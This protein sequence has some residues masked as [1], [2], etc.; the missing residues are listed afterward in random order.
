MSKNKKVVVGMSGGVDSSVAVVMLLEQGYDVIGLTMKTFEEASSA[1]NIR[2]ETNYHRLKAIEDAQLVASKL[3]IPHY[4]IDLHDDFERCVVQYFVDEYLHGRTPNPCVVC[5][6]TI[7]WGVMLQKAQELG[8][9]YFATGHYAGIRYHPEQKRY[10][11]VRGKH[12]EKDQ[13]YALWWVE[14]KALARTLFPLA[15][16][17]KPDVRQIAQRLELRTAHKEES[18][19]ICF[20]P[21]SQYDRFLKERIPTLESQVSGGDIVLDGRVVGK[22]RGYPFYTIGQRRDIGSYGEKMYVTKIDSEQNVITI[23]ND[24][25]LY[26]SALLAHSVNWMS[27][28]GTTEPLRGFAKVRYKDDATPAMLYSNSDGGIKVVFDSPKRAI[29]PGQS[30]VFYQNDEIICG[31]IIDSAMDA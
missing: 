12:A 6:R 29:T 30:V 11:V 23:G 26:H 31:G 17:T 16:L 18:F 25:L 28:E 3:G 10:T 24:E 9:S 15:E 8:A 2:N 14:Q 27:I 5:N 19:E 13:S 4:V 20:I 7:K 1:E 21:D 22:H